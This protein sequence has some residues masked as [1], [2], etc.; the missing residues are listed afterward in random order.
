[1]RVFVGVV[2]CVEQ[3]VT[4]ETP[5][6]PAEVV[7]TFV[8]PAP[9]AN[10][11]QLV[12]KGD[13][14]RPGEEIEM[15]RYINLGNVDVEWI[16]SIELVAA[17][18]LHHSIVSRISEEREDHEMEC[19]GFPH[20]LGDQIPLPVFA[21]STQVTDETVTLPEGVGME[22]HPRQQLIV[23]YHYLN[24]TDEPI[25]PEIY[26]NL[27]FADPTT[28][29]ARAGFYSF[30]NVGD[31]AVPPHGSQRITMTCP[32]LDPALLVTTT[33]HMHRLGRRFTLK[34]WDGEAP[35]ETLLESEG[36]L[37][38]VTTT[39]SPEI[40]IG[41]GEGLTFTCE[42][43][44]DSDETTYFGESSNHEMCFVYGF[45]Y[46]AEMDLVGLDGFGCTVDENVKTPAEL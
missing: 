9:P 38:P 15:C 6:T 27:H 42:W 36:W 32:F 39:F 41:D 1:M 34:R 11:T 26:L 23:N 21:T 35:A 18:G 12:V 8:P 44:S 16:S 4:L 29:D 25:K 19:F 2:G 30:T 7:E 24:V 20:D 31:I 13:R 43:E 14:L 37:D 46:P 3:P 10:G 33:P 17:P 22:F 5:E 45:F 40:L 28:V